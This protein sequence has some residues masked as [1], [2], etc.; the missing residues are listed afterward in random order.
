MLAFIP[1]LFIDDTIIL[2]PPEDMDMPSI[3]DIIII[4]PPR[5]D[6]MD[7]PSVDDIIIIIPPLFDDM[8]MPFIMPFIDD[9]IID[10]R[11]PPLSLAYTGANR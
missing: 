2:P 5:F 10:P 8:D 3:D 9:D 1:L 11:P 4:I 7:M 6:D